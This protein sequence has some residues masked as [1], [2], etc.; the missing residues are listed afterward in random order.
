MFWFWNTWCGVPTL[1]GVVYPS[2]LWASSW[3]PGGSWPTQNNIARGYCIWTE[4]FLQ[5]K[6]IQIPGSPMVIYLSLGW[7]NAKGKSE[8]TQSGASSRSKNGDAYFSNVT[9]SIQDLIAVPGPCEVT[10][11]LNPAHQAVSNSNCHWNWRISRLGDHMYLSE[12]YSK[13]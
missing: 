2:E 4:L 13:P 3:K 9:G 5:L 8:Q 6:R 10:E 1:W 12:L 7:T 11:C